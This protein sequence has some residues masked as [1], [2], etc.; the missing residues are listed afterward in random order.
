M[1]ASR[2]SSVLPLLLLKLPLQI[3]DRGFVHIAKLFSQ[4]GM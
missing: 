1:A 4:L 2:A 3:R